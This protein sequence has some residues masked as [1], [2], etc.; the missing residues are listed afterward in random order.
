MTVEP[1]DVPQHLVD[2]I[3]AGRCVAFVGAGFS[4]PIAGT[5]ADLLEAIHAALEVD[6]DQISDAIAAARDSGGALEYEAIGEMLRRWCRKQGRAAD[7]RFEEAVDAAL[8]ALRKRN[9]SNRGLVDER[10]RLLSQ[11]PFSAV[12][13]LN[14]D[15]TLDG[16]PPEPRAFR[17]VLRHR[18]HWWEHSEWNRA[19]GWKPRVIKLHGDAN[20]QAGRN[21]VV[22]AKSDYRRLLYAN[23]T[24]A[25][26]LRSVLA[27]HTV[28]Y[29]GFSFTDAYINELRSEVL[30]LIGLPRDRPSGYAILNDTSRAVRSFF[31]EAEGIHVLHFESKNPPAFRGFDQW[32]S[33]IHART[34]ARK[35]LQ[36]LLAQPGNMSQPVLWLDA[37]VDNNTFGHRWLTKAGADVIPLTHVDQLQQ[38]EHAS[39]RLIISNFG[40]RGPDDAVAFD[41]LQKVN[42]WPERPP[43]IVFAGGDHKYRNR[44]AAIRR[45]AWDY[46]CRW[47]ELFEL[48][49][50]LF[51]RYPKP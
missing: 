32:L 22:L 50:R 47:T 5:W 24:Y 44:L 41:L 25:N 21:P 2:E 11:I 49:E 38:D 45:G 51:G 26:F 9:K 4:A 40:F 43:V 12:L 39:A 23:G 36:Q 17:S 20:G 18:L 30:S 8:T 42:A 46:A 33:A 1:S 10:R 35:R 7:Q 34:S 15:P 29:V 27:T 37:A 31:H 16:M 19:H 48:I 13:T 14:M 28:L 3:L 6:D